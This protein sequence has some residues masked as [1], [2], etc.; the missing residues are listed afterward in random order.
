MTLTPE[1][2]NFFEKLPF[3]ETISYLEQ[4]DDKYYA[5]MPTVEELA[6]R[7]GNPKGRHFYSARDLYLCY[8][9]RYI[10]QQKVEIYD[11]NDERHCFSRRF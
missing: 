4:L 5:I 10:A 1:N 11:I 2:V 6:K 9:R 7:Y 3:A 8:Q